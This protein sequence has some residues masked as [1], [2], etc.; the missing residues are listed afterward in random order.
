MVCGKGV[1]LNAEG[2]QN[3]MKKYDMYEDFEKEFVQETENGTLTLTLEK[4]MS[5]TDTD[6]V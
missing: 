4:P 5:S 1:E 2:Y 3:Y 6:E